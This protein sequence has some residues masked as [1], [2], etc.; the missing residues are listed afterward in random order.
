MLPAI[1]HILYL[2]L[3]SLYYFCLKWLLTLSS[4]PRTTQLA[5]GFG[6]GFFLIC[7]FCFVFLFCF[8]LGVWGVCL[9]IYCLFV[10]V[11]FVLFS[12]CL[13]NFLTDVFMKQT[14]ERTLSKVLPFSVFSIT[15]SGQ[16]THGMSRNS[17]LSLLVRPQPSSSTV[18]S[19]TSNTE[20]SLFSSK[21]L[22]EV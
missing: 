5:L 18:Q 22:N 7:L 12:L 15:S 8:V 11:W 14:W 2:G 6:L 19:V 21:F 3:I 4:F 13:V 9:F 20:F 1:P 16:C 10:W 17:H